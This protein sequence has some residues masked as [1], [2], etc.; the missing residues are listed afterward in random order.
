MKPAKNML[1][2]IVVA[3]AAL[4]CHAE[5]YAGYGYEPTKRD[6]LGE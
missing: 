6:H 2:M 1:A 5:T 4:P 3:V